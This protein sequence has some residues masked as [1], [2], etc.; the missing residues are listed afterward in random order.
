MKIDND[1][2]ILQIDDLDNILEYEVIDDEIKNKIISN[3]DLN[4]KINKWIS[5]NTYNAHINAVKNC[6]VEYI[7]YDSLDFDNMDEFEIKNINRRI[8][9]NSFECPRHRHCQMFLNNIV[10]NCIY[11]CVVVVNEKSILENKNLLKG[12]KEILV[13]NKNLIKKIEY[14]NFKEKLQFEVM[15]MSPV[16]FCKLYIW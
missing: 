3:K 14:K 7:D 9:K 10:G 8:K 6:Y 2:S 1:K 11:I 4:R 16:L 13:S 12:M 15:K 5:N